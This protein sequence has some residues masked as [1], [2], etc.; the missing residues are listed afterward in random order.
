[1]RK[2]LVLMAMVLVFGAGSA[3]AGIGT[4]ALWDNYG[5]PGTQQFT[6]GLSSALVKADNMVRGAGLIA[7][8]GFHSFNS[9]GWNGNSA[10]DY[11]QFGF[12]VAA[13]Y[14]ATLD[15][16]FISTLSSGKGPGKMGVYT[17]LDGFANPIHTILQSDSA[18]INSVIDLSS[19]GPVTGSFT[20]RLMEIGNSGAGGYGASDGS[21]SFR[22]GQYSESGMIGETSAVP[23]PA[24]AW[25]M[26]SG[27]LGMA[28]FRRRI[29][30]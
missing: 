17:S 21:G 29:G 14:T 13:G 6:P 15:E 1:M 28:G 30:K 3:H 10:N 4:L 22:I 11:V 7:D 8:S 19:L 20:I 9:K 24:A 26:G 2:A 25:L 23:I 16:M 5:R 12:T 18:F 27:L